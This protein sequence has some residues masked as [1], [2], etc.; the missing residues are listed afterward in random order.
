M[1]GVDELSINVLGSSSSGNCGL[2]SL[3]CKNYL[4]DAGFTG[5]KLLLLL[6]QHDLTFEDISGVFITHEHID[7]IHGLKKLAKIDTI[8]FFANKETATTVSEKLKLKINWNVFDVGIPFIFDDL[9]VNTC[10]IFHDA[11]N[12]VGY[13]FKHK[14]DTADDNV[15]CWMTDIGCTTD[16][17]AKMAQNASHLVFESN[18]DVDMLI[19]D[20]KRPLSVKMRIMSDLGHLSNDDAFDFISSL[21]LN[22]LKYLTLIH[23]SNDCNSIKIVRKKFEKF[24]KNKKI[25]LNIIDPETKFTTKESVLL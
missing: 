18:H 10:E 15:I 19:S 12:P 24:C 21:N 7:H 3:G 13:S 6:Q 5:K 22:K 4:V 25:N 14:N 1:A 9:E 8:K 16:D 20:Y 2:I 17:M 11:V 23:L